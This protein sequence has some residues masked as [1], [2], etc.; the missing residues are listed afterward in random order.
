VASF[1]NNGGAFV[2]W[3]FPDE[4][5][6]IETVFHRKKGDGHNGGSGGAEF[7]EKKQEY[8]EKVSFAGNKK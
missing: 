3:G 6:T 4:G 1:P 8:P 5:K 2:I 7:G